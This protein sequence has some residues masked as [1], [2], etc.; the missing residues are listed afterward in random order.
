MLH[1]ASQE[2]FSCGKSGYFAVQAQVA[3]Y[4]VGFMYANCFLSSND[5]FMCFFSNFRNAR[6]ILIERMFGCFAGT[7]HDVC[8]HF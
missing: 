6:R 3:D 5:L 7:S 8:I 1:R 2:E 4:L